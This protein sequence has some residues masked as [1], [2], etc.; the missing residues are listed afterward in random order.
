VRLLA[1]SRFLSNSANSN[2]TLDVGTG[3][4]RDGILAAKTGGASGTPSLFTVS[5]F[6]GADVPADGS[7]PHF[8]AGDIVAW[9][10]DYDG[11]AGT[12]AANME[13]VFYFLEG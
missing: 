7:L 2:M 1:R 8:A 12:A 10:V 9:D 3:A 5:A 4:N 6:N 13:L 11:S